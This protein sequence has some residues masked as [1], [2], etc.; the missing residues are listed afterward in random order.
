MKMNDTIARLLKDL[1]VAQMFGV[2]GDVNLF[3]VDRFMKE[4][5]KYT[6]ATTESAAVLMASGW[7]QVTGKTGVATVT[8]GPGL[9]NALMPIVEAVAFHRQPQRSS[10]RSFWVPGAVHVAGALA[11]NEPVDESYLKSLGVL[12]QLP[13]WRQMAETMVERAE[14]QAA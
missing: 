9:V 11:S 13:S 12:D 6:S 8:C 10:L 7:A 3:I 1:G 14:E 4:G 2:I 5:G